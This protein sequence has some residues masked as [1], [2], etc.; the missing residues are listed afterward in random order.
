MSR[1]RDLADLLDASGDVKS[2]ALDNVPASNDA[3]ALTTGTLDMARVAN[4]S[5]TNA[6][7]AS[8]AADLSHDTTPQLGGDLDA[9]SNDISN[10]G[11]I[12]V[13]TTAPS[14]AAMDIIG[15]TTVRGT[16]NGRTLQLKEDGFGFLI[17]ADTNATDLTLNSAYSAGKVAVKTAGTE[18]M[19]VMPSGRMEF[20]TPT[21]TTGTLAEQRLDWR[22]ENNA[23][24]MASIG[25]HREAGYQAPSA[26]VF[27]TSTNVDS[28]ANN[29]D[30]DISE[31][32][33]I[34]SG[35][36]VTTPNQPFFAAAWNQSATGFV[37]GTY[38]V[39][40]NNGGF[41]QTNGKIYVPTAGWYFINAYGIATDQFD[42][43]CVANTTGASPFLFDFRQSTYA[44][45]THHG[46]GN[47][48]VVY[49]ASGSY[50]GI[51]RLSSTMYASAGTAHPH[52]LIS[53]MLMG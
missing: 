15:T 43:R 28:A 2:A 27:R 18:R 36:I 52:N 53:I 5:V 40:H 46:C 13:G 19:R 35:G 11:A 9:Q 6:H 44:S 10:A 24:V 32:M 14:N 41:T 8:G 38:S 4:G 23:G 31:K 34:S 42:T 20:Q 47:G 49:L 51:Y 12:G 3:S 26:L 37:T 17:E 16:A 29:S 48:R 1:A 50:V 30:G 45:G 33:R 22:N 7:F 21:A 25:V 39:I